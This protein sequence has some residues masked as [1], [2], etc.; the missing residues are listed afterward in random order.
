MDFQRYKEEHPRLEDRLTKM[1]KKAKMA[2]IMLDLKDHEGM[3]LL[4][5]EMEKIINSINMQLMTRERLETEK[6][7]I[8]MAD[9][10]RCMWL[11]S[12]FPSAEAT[13]KRIETYLKK[14]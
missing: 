6:R 2:D 10:E 12:L 9:K 7:E 8:L 5:T 13:L 3:Q 4:T 11:L 1:E 14:L